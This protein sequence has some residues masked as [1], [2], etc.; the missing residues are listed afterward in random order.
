MISSFNS[1]VDRSDAISLT[2]SKSYSDDCIC[3]LT[4][5]NTTF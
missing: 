3:T 4:D 2:V 5:Q 1:I